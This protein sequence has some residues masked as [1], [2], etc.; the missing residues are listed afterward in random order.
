MVLLPDQDRSRWDQER[1]REGVGLLR[2]AV[3]RSGGAPG[4]Y[5]LQ[6]HLA[7]CHSTA[8]SYAE[9]DWATIVG[10]YDLLV[11]VSPGSV[12]VLNRAVAV[13]EHEGPGAGLSALDL[14]P[15][16]DRGHLWH[17]ARAE[18]LS[19]LGRRDEALAAC[20]AALTGRPSPPERR[21][22]EGRRQQ[23]TR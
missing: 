14:V 19:R 6:A 11:H 8:R 1:I 2:E 18:C 10:L 9:T 23:L 13:L 21:L 17:A 22:L 15:G 4:Y 12:T 20:D 16:A 5:Q 3:R 7:A